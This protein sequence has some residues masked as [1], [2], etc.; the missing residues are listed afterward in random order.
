MDNELR[1]KIITAIVFLEEDKNGL[2]IHLNGFS[3]EDHANTFLK[4]LMK[5][6]GIEYTSI[7]DLQDLPTIH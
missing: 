5:N 2:I 1:N 7:R 3:D 4:K 6:S